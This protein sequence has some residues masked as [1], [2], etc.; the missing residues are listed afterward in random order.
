MRIAQVAPLHEA[1]PPSLYGGTERVVA[2]LTEELIDLGHQVTLFAS[3]DSATR[4]PLVSACHRSLR[5]DMACQDRMIYHVIQLEQLMSR[6]RD[7]DLIHFHTDYFHYP[8]VRRCPVPTLTTLHG[9]Q[10]LPDLQALYRE[11]PDI[12]LASISDSQRRPLPWVNWR[13]TVHHGLPEDVFIAGEG[14]GGYLAFLG[15]ISSE[16]RCDR[17]I[18]IAIRLGLPLKIAAKIED[19]DRPYFETVRHL[20]DHPLVEYIGEIGETEKV[21]FL[22]QARALLFPVD[23]PEPFGL[24]MIEAMACG[25]PVLAFRNGSV[26]EII[27]DGVTGRIVETVDEAVAVMPMVLALDR[28]VCR[29]R[30]LER[31]TVRRMAEDYLA[32]YRSLTRFGRVPLRPALDPAAA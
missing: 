15:R 8:L 21:A 16:K 28:A 11:Y 19:S 18:E 27:D 14:Q 26:P 22:G 31:F 29:R 3:G 32:L 5:L 4:A 1:V 9:R 10:D 7:F 6:W 24:V 13:G 17:A 25:T 20:F 12:P 23:W 30:F 2:H